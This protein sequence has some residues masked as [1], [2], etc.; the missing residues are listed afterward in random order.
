MEGNTRMRHTPNL[1]ND[2]QYVSEKVSQALAKKHDIPDADDFHY[3]VNSLAHS[4]F[5]IK[6]SYENRVTQRQAVQKLNSIS[7][8]AKKLKR[9]L[10]ELDPIT[11]RAMWQAHWEVVRTDRA[12][13][14]GLSVGQT[15]IKKIHGNPKSHYRE[16]EH[17][18]IVDLID[19]TTMLTSMDIISNYAEYGKTRLPPKQ[20]GPIER[21][22]VDHL[23]ANF[24]TL[25]HDDLGR[26]F[27]CDFHN[28]EC[29]TPAYFFC[30]DTALAIDPEITKSQI[31]TYMR[32]TITAERRRLQYP[33]Y[34]ISLD[35]GSSS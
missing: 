9:L 19:D 31:K 6:N 21:L 25:W 15:M 26:K 28:G 2:G 12:M 7:Q 18:Y 11:D 29:I 3:Y 4:Y 22:S 8:T 5:Q 16:T 35:I 1:H 27:T 20:E 13:R 23:I 17:S 24:H 10:E 14:E 30:E 34:K 33:R 32:R